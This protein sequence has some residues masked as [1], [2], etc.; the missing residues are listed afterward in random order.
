ML[1]GYEGNAPLCA[2][3]VVL[4]HLFPVPPLPFF[5]FSHC[6]GLV[7]EEWQQYQVKPREGKSPMVSIPR[8]SEAEKKERDGGERV[9]GG[10][11]AGM[12]GG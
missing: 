10:G 3:F 8:V 9:S 4:M 7:E 6:L 11:T 12:S 5:K 1:D 2:A